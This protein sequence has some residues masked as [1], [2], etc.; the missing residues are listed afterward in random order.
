MPEGD[1]VWLAAKRL[2]ATLAGRRLTRGEL[3]VPELATTD[4]AGLAVNAV[5]PVGK[6]MLT[7][8]DDGRTLHT[9]LRMD[10]SWLISPAS[11]RWAVPA[12]QV[13]VVL[14][15]DRHQALGRRM[16][17]VQVLPTADEG[18]VVGHLG[19]DILA[20]E[21]DVEEAARRI[22]ARPAIAI[23]EALLDQRN[24]AGIGNLYENETL[25]LCGATPW[26]PVTDVAD[27]RRILDLAHRLM[28]TNRE[29]PEQ[30]TTGEL[31]RGETH[32]VYGRAGEAC[33]RCRTGIR[34]A[35]LGPVPATRI[36]YWCPTCQAGPAPSVD[37]A[38]ARPSSQ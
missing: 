34:H 38:P 4:L 26:T 16:H 11:A 2:D 28:S 15:T 20:A 30:T 6:H 7:R 29:H 23:G 1:T 9:H 24:V 21:W 35:R 25:F 3:R 33:R 22:G 14:A 10:G 12:H 13:R 18:R 27:V 17:D 37:P 36:T 5:V 32:W 19:P 8:L 31:R